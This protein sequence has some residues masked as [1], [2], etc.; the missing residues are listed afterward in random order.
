MRRREALLTAVL[1]S[2]VVAAASYRIIDQPEELPPPYKIIKLMQRQT[3]PVLP[4]LI[5]ERTVGIEFEGDL[6]G[7]GIILETGKVLTAAHVVGEDLTQY[8]VRLRDVSGS[9]VVS[10]CRLVKIDR[11]ADL[12]LLSCFTDRYG[13]IDLGCDASIGTPVVMS[14]SPVGFNAGLL[15]GLGFVSR[16]ENG[17]WI[18]SPSITKGFSGGG[19]WDVNS[20][21]LIGIVHGFVGNSFGVT[22]P[23]ITLFIPS[24]AVE[25]FLK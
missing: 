11:E 6:V 9:V 14:G 8:R 2:M 1:C 23:G 18:A 12:A 17:F 5:F 10:E 22:A 7:A 16:K 24:Q 4:S 19:V 25:E 21:V 3:Y 13:K 15:S 20:G